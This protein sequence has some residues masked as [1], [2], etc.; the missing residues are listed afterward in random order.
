METIECDS[1]FSPHWGSQK[2][3]DSCKL[4]HLQLPFSFSLYSCFFV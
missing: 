1:L 3:K 2:N 4:I